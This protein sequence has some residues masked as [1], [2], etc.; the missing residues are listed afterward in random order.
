MLENRPDC[1]YFAAAG[2]ALGT[3][4]TLRKEFTA[5]VPSRPHLEW[6]LRRRVLELDNIEIVRGLVIEHRFEPTTQ[7][8]SGVLVAPPT[9]TMV[10]SHSFWPPTSWSTRQAGV[11][12]YRFG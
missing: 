11:P 10:L 6:Q 8:V 12:A 4:H 3:G 7:T 5:Y 1:I 2:H 9:T